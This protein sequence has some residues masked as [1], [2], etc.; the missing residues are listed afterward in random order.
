MSIVNIADSVVH[1]GTNLV[2]SFNNWWLNND[3]SPMM[4]EKVIMVELMTRNKALPGDSPNYYLLFT[5]VYPFQ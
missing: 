3:P 5:S 4:A 1:R 2:A